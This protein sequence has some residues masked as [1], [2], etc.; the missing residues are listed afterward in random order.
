MGSY[1]VGM[2]LYFY[3]QSLFFKILHQCFSALVAVHALIFSG[4]MVHCCIVVDDGD[5]L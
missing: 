2:R 4:I 1:V 3:K 5:L